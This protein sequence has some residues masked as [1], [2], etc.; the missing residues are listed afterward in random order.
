MAE[1]PKRKKLVVKRRQL[2]NRFNRE[3]AMIGGQLD[4]ERFDALLVSPRRD[5]QLVDGDFVNS[6]DEEADDERDDTPLSFNI[7]EVSETSGHSSSTDL[8]Q[9]SPRSI[10]FDDLPSPAD[11]ENSA[12]DGRSESLLESDSDAPPQSTTDESGRSCD[13]DIDLE[14][15]DDI[16]AILNAEAK[17]IDQDVELKEF[18]AD[19]L[20]K[21]DV[22]VR[23]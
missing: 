4:G 23:M 18:L 11:D 10:N 16:D 9:S 8:N 7:D 14:D 20:T 5:V 19:W 21:E 6:A 2:I 15:W 12:Y 3:F 22:N 17:P 13:E 1:P